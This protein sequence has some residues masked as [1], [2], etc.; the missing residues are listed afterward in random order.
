[1]KTSFFILLGIFGF[2]SP[3]EHEEQRDPCDI[4]IPAVFMI[5]D[6]ELDYEALV[7]ECDDLLLNVCNDSMDEAYEH[8][9]LMLH[10]IELYA[11][12]KK[13][14]IRGVK[15]WLNAFWNPDGSIR[16]LVYYPK[17]N[18]RNMDFEH[19]TSF[20]NE[21]L[22]GYQFTKSAKKCFAHYGSASFPTHT[23]LY[24]QDSTTKNK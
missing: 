15:L 21:F 23:D 4:N 5:G 1:M 24:F 14:E 22:E 2:I 18:C 11:Q 20:F 12:E 8:W 3:P 17:P 7:V 19:L 6:Y 13:V 16:H 10:D 9:L